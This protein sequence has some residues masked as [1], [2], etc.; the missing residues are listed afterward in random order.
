MLDLSECFEVS[1]QE[2][3]SVQKNRD[4]RSASDRCRAKKNAWLSRWPDQEA[5]QYFGTRLSS[6]GS[7]RK[8]TSSVR[9][10]SS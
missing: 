10:A 3:H 1:G 6:D 5:L 2:G 4:R 8:A 9:G 7:E